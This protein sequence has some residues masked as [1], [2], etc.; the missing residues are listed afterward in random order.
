MLGVYMHGDFGIIGL[1]GQGVREGAKIPDADVLDVTPTILYSLGHPVARDMDGGVLTDAFD[2]K[3]L[4]AN[5]VAFVPTYE[6]GRRQAGEPLES[7]VDD[8]VKERLRALGYIQ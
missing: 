2:L 8:K 6:T 3:F 5:R 7:P 1:M 4:K